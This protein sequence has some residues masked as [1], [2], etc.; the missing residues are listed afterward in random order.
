MELKG[1]LNS[2]DSLQKERVWRIPTSRF[3]NLIQSISS[4][5]KWHGHKDRHVNQWHRIESPEINAHIYGHLIFSKGA[6]I[7][8]GERLVFSK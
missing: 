5:D 1:T 4:Q 7:I 3:Q 2:Q 6:K 8:H